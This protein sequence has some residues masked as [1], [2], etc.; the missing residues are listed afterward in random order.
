[1]KQSEANGF[2]CLV[3]AG[4]AASVAAYTFI[5]ASPAESPPRAPVLVTPAETVAGPD[6]A[7]PGI[8]GEPLAPTV[9][10]PGFE[11]L[12][13]TLADT[14]PALRDR[15][16]TERLPALTL[17]DPARAVRFAEL[18]ADTRLRELALLQ[19]A[20][21][22][23][24]CDANAAVQWA[25]SLADP[26]MRDAAITDIALALAETNPARAVALRER[27]V[28]GASIPDNT[29]VNLAH[30]WAERDFEAVLAWANAQPPGAQ[31]DQVLQRL[32]FVRAEAGEFD[33]AAELA[34]SLIAAPRIRAEA[35]AAVAQQEG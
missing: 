6:T 33:E 23:A 5:G 19:V 8:Q 4:V 29:L 26:S 30:Q 31:R 12:E 22:W 3:A 14:D 28:D 2:A 15:L 27:F 16:L 10:S 21:S 17:R 1:M 24:R 25:E 13:Q 18:L 34:R 9:E 20:M 32:V 7:P 11:A 35:L